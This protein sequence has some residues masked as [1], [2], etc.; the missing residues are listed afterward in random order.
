[1]CAAYFNMI[2][3][4]RLLL[5]YSN[6]GPTI[7]L[8]GTRY[9]KTALIIAA[10]RGFDNIAQQLLDADPS[11]RHVDLRARN[12]QASALL[13]AASKGYWNTVLVILS[14]KP[15]IDF[16]NVDGEGALH[17]AIKAQQF[18]AIHQ[19]VTGAGVRTAVNQK[20]RARDTPLHLAAKTG[21]VVIIT[22]ILDAGGDK[23]ALDAWGFVPATRAGNMGYPQLEFLING[24]TPSPYAPSP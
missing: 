6:P 7:A 15:T 20:N 8:V 19:M 10:Q 11:P 23:N 18:R 9:K 5:K 2:A 14:Y 12:T 24:Y 22:D 13:A 16:L 21:R 4:V 3:I 17:F 1:M